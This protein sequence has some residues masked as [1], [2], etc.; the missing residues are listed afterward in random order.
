MQGARVLTVN[1][2]EFEMVRHK[3]GLDVAGLLALV[4][5]I[6]VTRGA[7]GSTVIGPDFHLDIPAATPRRV[8]EPTGVGD[9]Y[10]AGLLTGLVHGYSWEV[11]C[12]L[13]SLAAVYVIENSGSMSHDYTLAEF[14]A[15]YRQQFG[16][17]PEL[18]DLLARSEQRS[19]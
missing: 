15:R 1:E 5:T 6:V 17:T 7:D 2:Y 19:R 4:D 12:R 11:I 8:V 16:D 10:R 13:A 3:S 18:D 9:A 14:V